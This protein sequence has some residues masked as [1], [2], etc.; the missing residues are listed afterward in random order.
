MARKALAVFLLLAAGASWSWAESGVSL[1]NG[2]LTIPLDYASKGQDG[3]TQAIRESQMK[4]PDGG[5]ISYIWVVTKDGRK[6][7]IQLP[8]LNP[9]PGLN[10]ETPKA[11]AKGNSPKKAA[12]QLRRIHRDLGRR[13]IQ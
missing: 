6:V 12:E 10:A 4:S 3:L 7:P 5:V 2:V 13:S 9:A 1:Q 8:A 11:G